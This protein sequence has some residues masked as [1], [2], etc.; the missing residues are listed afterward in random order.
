[1]TVNESTNWSK[2]SGVESKYKALGC[3][4]EKVNKDTFRALT[5]EIM[6]A[7]DG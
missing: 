1:M 5:K 2:R 7:N 6:D 3:S 4:I